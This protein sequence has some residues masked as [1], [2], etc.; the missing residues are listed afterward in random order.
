[1]PK[2]RIIVRNDEL[3]CGGIRQN[4]GRLCQHHSKM[5]NEQLKRTNK[6]AKAEF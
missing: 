3:R 4:V 5:S 2:K 6:D 1:M